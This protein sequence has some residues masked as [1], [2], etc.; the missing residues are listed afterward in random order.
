MSIDEFHGTHAEPPQNGHA[1]IDWADPVGRGSCVR[2]R[3][4]TCDCLPT[5]Y[6]FCVTGG[7][8]HIRRTERTSSGSR[9]SVSPWLRV[10]EAK[11]LWESLLEG[12]A[13]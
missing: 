9:V 6:E 1:T 8:G 7:L 10:A 5:S 3:D 12:R 13:R 2:V 11:R 4:H